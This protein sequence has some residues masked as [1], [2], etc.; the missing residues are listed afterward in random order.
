[1]RT[2][3][4][5]TNTFRLSS[6][7]M[8]SLT[9]E[10]A[11]VYYSPYYFADARERR[12]YD[13]TSQKNLEL[14][15]ES[16]NEFSDELWARGF[17][18]SVFKTPNVI[19]DI[20]RLVKKYKF[21][22][23]LLDRPLFG[24]WHSLDYEKLECKAEVIDSALIDDRCEKLTAKS[25]W[26]SH[27]KTIGDYTP[28]RFSDSISPIELN[29]DVTYYPR[30][31]MPRMDATRSLK[32]AIEKS[33][34]YHET[35]DQAGGQLELSV[36]LHN[37]RLDPRHVFFSIAEHLQLTA[38][39]D[40]DAAAPLR[41]LAFREISIMK[42]RKHNLTLED[43]TRVWAEKLMHRSEY[44]NL[45]KPT[46]VT[47]SVSLDQIKAGWTQIKPIDEILNHQ[48]NG[49]SFLSTGI[50]PNRARMLFASLVY[51]NSTDGHAALKT[52]I[53]TFDLIGID[54]Q[55]PNN[56]TQCISALGLSYGKV[57]KM[58][59]DTAFKKLYSHEN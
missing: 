21:D 54:G 59:V 3:V 7:L 5:M 19:E 52:L 38:T 29:E 44:D 26:I 48:T 28:F 37:G 14:F 56:Y 51:Y 33:S 30:R 35:R 11:F 57:L 42:A 6:R 36:I 15:Y 25:R 34:K 49:Q 2:L 17:D 27:L 50:M 1:M 43:S 12:I 18:L 46:G 4:W 45:S 39:A 23:I 55:S 31:E 16:I 20:N 8:S 47:K 32:T 13:C 41:Q 40:S 9:G 53:D 24:F 22:R 58:N 10:V